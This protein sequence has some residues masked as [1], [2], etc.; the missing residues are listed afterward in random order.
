MTTTTTT[1]SGVQ[2]PARGNDYTGMRLDDAVQK[3]VQGRQQVIVEYVVST[4]PAGVVVANAR[5]G[6]RER[7][8]VS[9]GA[10]PAPGRQVPDVA[11]EDAS[12]AE[13]DLRA[14]G[15]SVL[16]VSWPVSDSSN[17]GIVVYATPAAGAS[18]PRGA[19]VVVYVG[20]ATG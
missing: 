7:L 3:I 8:R 14:A 16:E 5:A 9:A 10:Q 11:G 15:F 12:S 6:S 2:P 4:E 19:A 17:D 13:Q 1:S 18:A 20:S